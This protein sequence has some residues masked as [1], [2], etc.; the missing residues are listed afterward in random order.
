MSPNLWEFL[1]AHGGKYWADI[2]PEGH[3]KLVQKE[4]IEF[5]KV[6]EGEGVKVVK[7]ESQDFGKVYS[8]PGFS[9]HGKRVLIWII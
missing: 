7:P 8:V 6:L 1:D 5:G 4:I 9:S 3:W 2:L